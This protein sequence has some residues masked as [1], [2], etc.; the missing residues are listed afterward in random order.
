MRVVLLGTEGYHPTDRGHT[1]CVMVPEA[2]LVFDAG[3]ALFRLGRYLETDSLDIVLSHAHLD[4]VIGLTYLL[5][6]LPD[7][8]LRCVTVHA[9][10]A[11]LDAVRQ[12]LF[13]PALFPVEPDFAMRPL[14]R[15]LAVG[16]GGRLRSFPLP[17]HPGGS[18]GFRVDWPG[19]SMAYITDVVADVQAVYVEEIR[20][21]DLLLHECNFPDGLAQWARTTGHSWTSEVAR[22]ARAAEVG[23]LVLT[24]IDPELTGDDPIDL[25]IAQAIFPATE[26]GHD[27][28]EIELSCV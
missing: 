28:Q 2:G 18:V 26:M 8:D 14:P 17:G 13:A 21:V 19:A 4:H 15:E 27:L 6:V 3:T 22:V 24:H 11:V 9:R 5:G 23:R 10:P 16:R 12:Q 20:G 7:R 1:A 25:A